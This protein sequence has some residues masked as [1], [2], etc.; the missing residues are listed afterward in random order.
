MAFSHTVT[1]ATDRSS[2]VRGDVGLVSGTWNSN[3]E[4]SGTIDPGA[5]TVLACGV[6]IGSAGT[7]S[8]TAQVIFINQN[9]GGSGAR[10]WGKIGLTEMDPDN[11]L[12]GDWWAVVRV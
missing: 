1:G 10:A 9:K 11:G 2:I 5:G 3:A 12:G 4:A 8:G 7:S 6:S